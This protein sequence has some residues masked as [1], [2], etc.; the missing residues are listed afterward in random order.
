MMHIAD[1]QGHDLAILH[2]IYMNKYSHPQSTQSGLN[3]P[4]VLPYRITIDFSLGYQ[5]SENPFQSW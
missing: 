3:Q 5:L 2:K 1:A 4:L